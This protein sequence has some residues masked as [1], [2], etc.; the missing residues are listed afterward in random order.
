M[1]NNP[2]P[3]IQIV[4][5]EDVTPAI[6]GD[7]GAMTSK[8]LIRRD[9]GSDRVSLSFTVT[10][11]T[12]EEYDAEYPEHDELMFIVSGVGEIEWEGSEATRVSAGMAIFVPQGCHYRYRVVE[13]PQEAVVVF[14]PAHS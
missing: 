7:T 3:E 11:E 1:S 14:G 9:I 13:A 8:R 6:L 5:A 10:E 4:S 2:S 12:F